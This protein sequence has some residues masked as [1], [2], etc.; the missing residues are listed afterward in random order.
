MRDSV[1]LLYLLT[2]LGSR[3]RAN[4]AGGCQLQDA[5]YRK[6]RVGAAP[7]P[8]EKCRTSESSFGRASSL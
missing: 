2:Y 5:L 4:S 7:T 6:R 8:R 1:R 3:T